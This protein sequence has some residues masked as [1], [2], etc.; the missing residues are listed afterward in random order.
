[1]YYW[2]LISFLLMIVSASFWPMMPTWYWTA[3]PVFYLIF[4]CKFYHLRCGIGI[5]LAILVLLIHGNIRLKQTALLHQFDDSIRVDARVVTIFRPLASNFSSKTAPLYQGE[6]RIHAINGEAIAFPFRPKIRLLLSQQLYPND[7]ITAHIKHKAIYGRLNEIGFDK[8]RHFMAQGIV[9]QASLVDKQQLVIHKDHNYRSTLHH[10]ISQQLQTHPYQAILLALSFGDRS[11]LSHHE[12]QAYRNSGLIHLVAISGL[13]IGIAYLVGFIVGT[14]L[15]RLLCLLAYIHPIFIDR[16]SHYLWLGTAM[17]LCGAY[18][19]AWLAGFSLPTVRAL[20]MLSLLLFFH[21]R[22]QRQGGGSRWLL[23]VAILLL[24]DPFAPLT[25]S[26]W[27][28]IGAVAILLW[29]FYHQQNRWSDSLK[30]K[31]LSLMYGQLLL[32]FMMFP[33]SAFFFSGISLSSAIYNLLFIPIFSFCIIP[34]LFVAIFSSICATS[35]GALPWDAMIWDLLRYPLDM[36]GWAIRYADHSWLYISQQLYIIGCWLVIAILLMPFLSTLMRSWLLL[37]FSALIVSHMHVWN[38]QRAEQLRVDILDVGHGLAMVLAK[39]DRAIIYDTGSGWAQGSYAQ[40]IIIPMLY[41]RG[42]K[43]LDHIIVSHFDNDHSGGLEEIV[44]HF[45]D[46]NIIASQ[47]LPQKIQMLSEQSSFTGCI[48][49][50][51]WQWQNITLDALWPPKLVQRAYNP[52][53]CVIKLT[54]VSSG[55]TFLLTG[56]ITQ[57]V[58][59]ILSRSSQV[60]KSDMMIVPHHGSL[61]S[62]TEYFIDMVNPRHA[63]ASLAKGGRWPLPHPEVVARYKKTR[64][65]VA[66]Y[67][68][69]GANHSF[70]AAGGA[71]TIMAK[72][73]TIF[74]LV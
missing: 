53:S 66:R 56:D 23:T 65:F 63:V 61:T 45:P 37:C 38:N 62:S 35:L 4:S 58:E 28:S 3:L 2:V 17:G 60:L 49:G 8:E 24:F 72:R 33:I 42:I 31:L 71:I 27:M 67:W 68:R 34:L 54:D 32:V 21:Y 59:W 16:Y 52:H 12:W 64:Y 6:I 36:V 30:G 39:N 20:I 44:R 73:E 29:L 43:H 70:F 69:V 47:A 1:M 55:F 11:L 13:H 48:N 74:S 46:V 57:A 50:V 25:G 41:Q 15:S 9:A 14:G 10:F 5:A 51:T 19:Y 7:K 22:Q 40:S 26:F 18:F